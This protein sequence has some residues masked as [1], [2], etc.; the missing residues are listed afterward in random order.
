MYNWVQFLSQLRFNMNSPINLLPHPHRFSLSIR[1]GIHVIQPVMLVSVLPHNKTHPRIIR[2]YYSKKA[3]LGSRS[4]YCPLIPHITACFL[5]G[6]MFPWYTQ[7]PIAP[8]PT[9]AAA[10]LTIGRFI[11]KLLSIPFAIVA[12]PLRGFCGGI[13]WSGKFV[14]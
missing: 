3:E 10:L 9:S 2:L 8:N 11:F 4:T 7:Y 13:W 14:W 6:A 1:I 12:I 5:L